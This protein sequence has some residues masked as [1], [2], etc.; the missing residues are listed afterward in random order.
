MSEDKEELKNSLLARL[1][2]AAGRAPVL[3]FVEEPEKLEPGTFQCA[4]CGE[5]LTKDEVF[6]TP[7]DS[8]PFCFSCNQERTEELAG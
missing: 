7:Y 3:S 2:G 4:W 1:R 8:E 6:Y 5:T